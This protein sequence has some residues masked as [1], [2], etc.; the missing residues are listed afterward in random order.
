MASLESAYSQN[1]LIN[2]QPPQVFQQAIPQFQIQYPFWHQNMRQLLMIKQQLPNG[3]GDN[4][5]KYTIDTLGLKNQITRDH[6]PFYILCDHT[7]TIATKNGSSVCAHCG[8][9]CKKT[10]PDQTI[11]A[12]QCKHQREYSI[13]NVGKQLQQ[14]GQCRQNVKFGCNTNNI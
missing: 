14:C 3:I 4:Y 13:F 9:F 1:S 7:K 8:W 2:Y 6:E 11:L 5:T 10:A 12:K